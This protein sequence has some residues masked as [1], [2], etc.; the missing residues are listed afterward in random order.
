MPEICSDIRT[1]LRKGCDIYLSLSSEQGSSCAME[2]SVQAV[3]KTEFAISVPIKD[4]FVYPL[5]KGSSVDVYFYYGGGRYSFTTSVTGRI[6]YNDK[7]VIKCSL[8]D[9]IT[10]SERRQ[11]VRI[12]TLMSIKIHIL[13]KDNVFDSNGYSATCT[14]IS[15][16]GLEISGDIKL[17]LKI[18]NIVNIDFCESLPGIASLKAKVVRVPTSEKNSY[19]LCF[20]DVPDALVGRLV[21]YVFK[22]QLEKKQMRSLFDE[23]DAMGV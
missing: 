7:P 21:K 17:H 11:F 3:G 16:G 20:I 6:I 23:M 12:D 2:S 14:D 5:K 1:V 8:P 10:R 4:G 19:G 15:E 18:N 22:K 13:K 9:K